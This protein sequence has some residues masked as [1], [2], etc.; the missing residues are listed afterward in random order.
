MNIDVEYIDQT[1]TTHNQTHRLTRLAFTK[2]LAIA[3]QR[4]APKPQKL[5]RTIALFLHYS[6]YILRQG[7][8]NDRFSEPPI[9]LSDPTEKGQ[10]SSLAGKAIADFLSKRIDNSI[11][12]VKYEAAM[13]M[14]GMPLFRVGRPV[15][16]AFTNNSMFA[17]EAKGFSNG[18]GNMADHK[19]QSKTGGIPVNFSVACVSY[20]L[21]NKVKCKY[22]DPFNDNF[23]YQEELFVALTK[24]YYI[25]LSEFLNEEYFDY[26]INEYQGEKFYE[27]HLTYRL[28]RK[29]FRDE[30]RFHPFG[31]HEFFEIYCPT[32]LLPYQIED[33][34]KIGMS[35]GIRSFTLQS[36]SEVPNNYLYIDND[37]IGLRLRNNRL[38]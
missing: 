18:P 34:A 25:D 36:E 37:R 21:Y 38:L 33:Y 27:V 1:G 13:R 5:I 23:P 2:H 28:V 16:L 10:F 8:R 11:Y 9:L 26:D 30:M 31:R 35:K 22:H 19:A 14:R 15:L 4:Y 20:N 3:G 29:L 7:F 12:I 17:P 32:L 6:S 24:D